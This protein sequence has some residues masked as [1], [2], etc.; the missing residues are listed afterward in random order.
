MTAEKISRKELLK[1][2][3]EFITLSSKM[4]TLAK[5]HQRELKLIGVV[6][7]CLVLIYLGINTY[8]RYINNRAQDAYNI[9]YYAISKNM[10]SRADK[11]SV[12]K[13]EE[14]FN[15][16]SKK[17][18]ISKAA[19]L[20]LPELAYVNFLQQEYDEAI[21]KYQEFLAN[22]PDGPYRSLAETAIAVCYEEKGDLDKALHTL[23][24]ISSG[25]NDF[26][27]E[28]ALLSMARIYRAKGQK[29]KSNEILNEFIKDFAGS[30]FLPLAK[31]YLK[32]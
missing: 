24:E 22:A 14:L 12:K 5:D 28:Q 13:S 6:L 8:L 31:A 26:F 1:T 18:G 23:E 29:E 4:I 20:V 27:K 11:D 21:S 7:V 3:D 9:A 19:R 32:P 2:E 30:Q 10:D 25:P 16:V 15:D 17:Y